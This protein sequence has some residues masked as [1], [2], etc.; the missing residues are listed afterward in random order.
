MATILL[1]AAGAAIGG[2][3]GGSVLGLSMTALGRFAGA[4]LGRAIDQS[5]MGAGSSAVEHGKVERFRLTS[6]GE[7]DPVA[8]VFGRMRVAGHVIWATQFAESVST[9]GGGKGVA[10]GPKTREYSYTVSLAV[11]LCEG[12]IS[13][14]GRVWA[15][16]VQINPDSLNMRVYTGADDQMPD[17][18]MEA[19]EGAGQVPAYRGTAYLV[20]EDLSLEQF[21]NR[22]PQFEFEVMRAAQAEGIDGGED[23]AH[24]T[25]AVAMM[26]GSGEYALATSPVRFDYGAGNAALANVNTPAGKPDFTVATE[27]LQTE[28]PNLKASSLIVSWF[29]NDLRCSDC[30][31]KPKVEQ[32]E[33]DA[34][35]AWSVSGVSREFAEAVARDVTDRPVYGG[36]PAD[37]AV[38]EAIAHMNEQ[39][40]DVLYYPFILMDQL[41]DNTL[42][43]PYTGAAG[44]P[45]FPWRGR[46]TLSAAPGST[47]S[48]DGTPDADVEVAAFFGTATASDFTVSEGAVSYSGPEEWSYRRFILHNA[49]LCAAAGGVDAFSIGSEMRALSAVR[50]AAGFTTVTQFKALAAEVRSLFGA[51]TKI[52]Y[53]ADW[54]EYF[55]LAENGDRL[56]N[57]DPLWSDSN[58]DFIG[59]DNYMPMSD[60]RDGQDHADANYGSIYNL[61]YLEEN[62]L[63]GEGYDWF[64]HSDE[65]RE[66]QIRT[67]ITDGAHSEPWVWRY[68][69]IVNFWSSD[70]H[71]RV[72]GVRSET[73][74]DWVPESKPI[75]FTELGCAAVDKGTNQ[76]N[77]FVDP[78][79][80]E[81]ALPHYS[82][83]RQDDY[84]QAQYIRAMMRF[85]QRPENN[86][87]STEYN[88][89]MLDMS[90][91]FVWAW[92]AR[93][94]PHFPALP[95]VWS[96]ASNYA[97]G[98]WITG[99]ASNRTLASVVDE[100]C[101][102]AGCVSFDVSD[103]KGVVEGYYVSEVEEGRATLQP[104]ML[105]Y[106]FDAVERDGVMHFIMRDGLE[107]ATLEADHVVL[108][109]EVEAEIERTRAS[110]AELMGRVR[111][112]FIQSDADFDVIAEEAVLP[113]HETHAVAVSELPLVMRRGRGRQIVERWLSEAR[114]ARDTLRF[115]LPPSRLDVAAGDVLTLNL[116]E[117]PVK[118][119]I[120]KVELGAEQ[121][122]EALRIEPESYNPIEV[123]ED[124]SALPGFTPP[125][126]VFPLFLDL[127][128]MT[129][130][131]VPHAPHLAITA[132]PWPGSAALY[133]SGDDQ[134]YV[135]QRLITR[136]S[137][138]G[139]LEA[140]LPKAC[141]ALFDRGGKLTV[142]LTSG[143]FS[144]V[145][146]MALLNGGNV[147]AVGDGSPEN[148][149][150]LQFQE[151][152]LVGDKTYELSRLLRG[153]LGTNAWQPSAWPAGSY[154]VLLDGTPEQLGLPASERGLERHY[155]VGPASRS[156]DDPSYTHTTA[157]FSGVGLKPLSPAHVTYKLDGGDLHFSWIRRTRIDGDSW[158]GLD[159]P[160]GEESESYVLRIV[161]GGSVLRE[162]PLSTPEWTYTAT[163]ISADGAG[164]GFEVHVSQVSATYGLGA[165]ANLTVS[166]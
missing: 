126:P 103:L 159:V 129:G 65:A 72:N 100:V 128:L 112:R 67:P 137:T 3:L 8:Q 92:D 62:I 110:E 164:T 51:E 96:D 75:W 150:I 122:V 7:G 28:L 114:V 139:V 155:R 115:A 120:D 66:A 136:R 12:V 118:L 48:P 57:L 97:R 101:R 31:I 106:G 27:R 134:G 21:G 166:L 119:R 15:D 56:F 116:P 4:S 85:W 9:S 41:G 111:L 83:G 46:I 90:R 127:P 135:F 54:S 29:G 6:S 105:A 131:E 80:S 13:G 10:T 140:P 14:V 58:I 88:A 34:D 153:Q 36:T 145:T 157:A 161:Q 71:E 95:Q 50:G 142:K 33:H 69:D 53:C 132:E 59:I 26:P 162:E 156:Y 113:D 89:P 151:A 16:G 19:V 55:G 117:G 154:F 109:E 45:A 144:S 25:Q 94:Y 148:W 81:S 30:E 38:I 70:H 87:V 99:R 47:T 5:I 143:T 163:N 149:E 22:V 104:L 11:G 1:S 91:A 60:W 93:P 35:M 44:Q 79:S 43:D 78:K 125:V 73:P 82:N 146:E 39:G 76:P 98:H 160:L 133:G 77:K 23:I 138:L 18:K 61:E 84:L 64:Y 102:R 86:P 49:A 124:V 152:V 74:T 42:P 52:G 32:V 141:P 130:A 165:A 68:K 158:E 17:P 40:I 123:E 2:S 37:A 20:M 24:A 107:D 121:I 147:A 108:S 63:G